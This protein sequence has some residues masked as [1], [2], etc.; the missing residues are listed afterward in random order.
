MMTF[1]HPIP[2]PPKE[3][4][5]PKPLSQKKKAALLAP[6]DLL[7]TLET[8]RPERQERSKKEVKYFD[9]FAERKVGTVDWSKQ[10]QDTSQR[11][12]GGRKKKDNGEKK[13]GKK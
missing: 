7:V 2:P 6:P 11:S 10:K 13:R 5:I 8:P 12:V 4:R 9:P 3:Q 1:D